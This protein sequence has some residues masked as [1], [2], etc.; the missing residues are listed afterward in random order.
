MIINNIITGT[1]FVDLRAIQ[2]LLM[3]SNYIKIAWRNFRKSRFYA[4]VNVLGLSAGIGFTL[5]VAAFV[6]KELNV[7]K[8]LKNADHHRHAG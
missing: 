4:A 8:G 5:L 3:F 2:F 1:L 6:W 7:N